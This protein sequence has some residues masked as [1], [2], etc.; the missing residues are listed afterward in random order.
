MATSPPHL[1]EHLQLYV[2]SSLSPFFSSL[3]SAREIRVTEIADTPSYSSLSLSPFDFVH[4]AKLLS[5]NYESVLPILSTSTLQSILPFLPLPILLKLSSSSRTNNSESSSSVR[6]DEE[7]FGTSKEEGII[8]KI[9]ELIDFQR[10]WCCSANSGS[11]GECPTEFKDKEYL[12][13]MF[14]NHHNKTNIAQS[15]DFKSLKILPNGIEY[16]LKVDEN[17]N[18]QKDKEVAMC[19][20]VEEFEKNLNEMSNGIFKNRKF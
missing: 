1:P 5:S 2:L 13:D 12:I 7:L 6:V 10:D 8:G 20:D 18:K 9:W 11:Y 3:L 16:L 14:N 15:D 17:N 19:R 4:S